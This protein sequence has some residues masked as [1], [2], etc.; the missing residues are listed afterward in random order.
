LICQP[1]RRSP[2]KWGA[3]A[4]LTDIDTADTLIA[5]RA[6]MDV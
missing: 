6:A 4:A 3:S 5:V 2:A 1:K